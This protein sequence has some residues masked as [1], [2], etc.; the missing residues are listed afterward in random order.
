MSG[1]ARWKENRIRQEIYLEQLKYIDTLHSGGGLNGARSQGSTPALFV[2]QIVDNR[3]DK[4]IPNRRTENRLPWVALRVVLVAAWAAVC[5]WV[6]LG[7]FG[8]HR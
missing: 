7:Q 5:L 6:W 3:S 4:E 1:S 8:I 2:Q